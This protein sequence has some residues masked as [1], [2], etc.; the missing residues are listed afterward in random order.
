MKQLRFEPRTLVSYTV[1][2]GMGFEKP[3]VLLQAVVYARGDG[4]A[5]VM[6][7]PTGLGPHAGEE[8]GMSGPRTACCSIDVPFLA[9]FLETNRLEFEWDT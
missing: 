3:N 9:S 7:P 4:P 6:P 1:S 2:G 8:E 5:C